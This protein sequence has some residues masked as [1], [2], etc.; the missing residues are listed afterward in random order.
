MAKKKT[1][2]ALTVKRIEPEVTERT[3]EMAVVEDQGAIA[4]ARLQAMVDIETQNRK[5][6]KEFI[7]SH[8]VSGTDFGK[9]HI[10]RDCPDKYKCTN[11]YHFS[12]DSLFKSGTEKF[13]SLFRLRPVFRRDNDTWEMANRRT[14]LFCFVC[15][16]QDIRGNVLAE[17]RGACD[18]KEK[19]G[20]VNVAIKIA[21][22]RAQTDAVLRHGALS[23][24]FTQDLEDMAIGEET[25]K[26]LPHTPTTPP[27]PKSG[28]PAGYGVTIENGKAVVQPVAGQGQPAAPT[29]KTSYAEP[30][31]AANEKKC[32]FCGLWHT[33]MYDKCRDCYFSGVSAPAAEQKT[34]T[35]TNYDAPPFP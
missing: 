24:F 31:G 23:D 22:K 2:K 33:G 9:I 20:S 12:K 26:H 30:T 5:I 35:I 25:P 8:L 18:A 29:K 3:N 6:L 27:A 13:T 28:L 34:K 14:D 15:E 11:A 7:G 10:N 16:L 32:K 17:G 19:Q 4:P 21:Q 1:T